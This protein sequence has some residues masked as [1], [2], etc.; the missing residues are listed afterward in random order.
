MIKFSAK[1]IILFSFFCPLISTQKR[2]NITHCFIHVCNIGAR[3]AIAQHN[4]KKLQ[5]A[6]RT[7][8]CKDCR[9]RH[10]NEIIDEEKVR[11]SRLAGVALQ[12]CI[13]RKC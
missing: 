3:T 5:E 11:H 1:K 4:S 8:P 6:A 2:V 10:D 7:R 9:H 13:L 12:E